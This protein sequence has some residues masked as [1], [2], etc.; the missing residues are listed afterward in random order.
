MGWAEKAG[1][2]Q[3]ARRTGTKDVLQVGERQAGV[4]DVLDDDD[5]APL[6]PRIEILQEL[7]LSGR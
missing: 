4:D 6:D 3:A 5:V 2:A 7:D 1:A